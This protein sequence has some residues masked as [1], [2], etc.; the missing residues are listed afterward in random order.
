MN[1]STPVDEPAKV[2]EKG[3]KGREGN[4]VRK[5]RSGVNRGRREENVEGRYQ[6]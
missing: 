1:K 2:M 3:G 4:G 6:G 5:G